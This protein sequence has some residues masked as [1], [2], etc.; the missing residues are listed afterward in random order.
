MKT[1]GKVFE[2]RVDLELERQGNILLQGRDEKTIFIAKREQEQIA[3]REA[4]QK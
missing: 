1:R 3:M 4:L 2:N